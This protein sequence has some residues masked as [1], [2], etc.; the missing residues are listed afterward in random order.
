MVDVYSILPGII[1]LSILPM[2]TVTCYVF[3]FVDHSLLGE[4]PRKREVKANQAYV[5]TDY[6]RQKRRK[7]MSMV[8]EA[9]AVH[10][11]SP[12]QNASGASVF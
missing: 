11:R 8:E 1:E 12:K 2:Q 10:R 4:Q 5:P 3:L 6:E 7:A 9:N